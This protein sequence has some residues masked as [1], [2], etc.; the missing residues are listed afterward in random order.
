MSNDDREGHCTERRIKPD[1]RWRAHPSEADPNACGTRTAASVSPASRSENTQLHLARFI[2]TTGTR[3][4][5]TI[6]EGEFRQW[7]LV[8]GVGRRRQVSETASCR[9]VLSPKRMAHDCRRDERDC[10]AQ[11]RE[12]RLDAEG[13]SYLVHVR[14]GRGNRDI[15]PT[16]AT[17]R[18][19]LRPRRSAA[20]S[21]TI[22]ITSSSG[23]PANSFS[24]HRCE[25]GNAPSKCG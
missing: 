2:S 7:R 10:Q 13:E 15:R 9:V 17:C 18:Q 25:S 3:A 21:W 16:E 12:P 5:P 14:G 22:F 24:T 8:A 1:D 19:T 20:L 11:R 6:R 23:T 4:V